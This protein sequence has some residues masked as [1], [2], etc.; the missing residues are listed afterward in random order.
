MLVAMLGNV[1]A[2]R[3]RQVPLLTTVALAAGCFLAWGALKLGL[4]LEGLATA[5]MTTQ[6]AYALGLVALGR[7]WTSPRRALGLA[8]GLAL[9]VLAACGFVQL[10]AA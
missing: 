3:Q 6:L 9:P 8:A 4:G 1:A 10:V 7:P 2:D 5:S